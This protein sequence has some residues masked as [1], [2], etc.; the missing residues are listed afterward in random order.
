MPR[1]LFPNWRS[2]RRAAQTSHW[3]PVDSPE[4]AGLLG[5]RS[6]R[7]LTRAQRQTIASMIERHVGN[8]DDPTLRADVAAV[9]EGRE[10]PTRRLHRLLRAACAANP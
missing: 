10:L 7:Q 1:E 6:R 9:I 3:P 5:G 4:I 8:F 2:R